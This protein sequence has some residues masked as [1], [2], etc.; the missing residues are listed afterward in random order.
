M[1][2]QRPFPDE[3]VVARPLLD[4]AGIIVDTS[5]GGISGSAVGIVQ[6]PRVPHVAVLGRGHEGF[7]VAWSARVLLGVQ[8]RSMHQYAVRVRPDL[9][10]GVGVVLLECGGGQW[11]IGRA[12]LIQHV[13]A[14]ECWV[15]AIPRSSHM[16]V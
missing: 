2:C 6:V 15:L 11:P 16:Q 7:P 14:H 4:V 3:Q 10:V 12:W 5:E 9:V 1:G 13:H 8:E